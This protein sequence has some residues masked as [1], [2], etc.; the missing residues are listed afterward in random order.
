VA[1][2][3]RAARGD[4]SALRIYADVGSRLGQALAG[5]V[6]LLEPEVIVIGGGIAASGAL[7]FPAAERELTARSMVARQKSIPLKGAHFGPAAGMIGAALLS[8]SD[9]ET[10]PVRS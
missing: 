1:V 4:A 6:N 5:F 2:A 3:E 10:G 9:R 8:L 7:L